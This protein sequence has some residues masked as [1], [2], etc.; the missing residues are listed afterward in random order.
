MSLRTVPPAI[1]HL[2]LENAQAL[3]YPTVPGVDGT[4]ILQALQRAMLE[5][6]TP[7]RCMSA[8]LRHSILQT[9][10]HWLLARPETLASALHL[11]EHAGADAVRSAPFVDIRLRALERMKNR[12]AMIRNVNRLVAGTQLTENA[13][14]LLIAAIRRNDIAQLISLPGRLHEIAWGPMRAD[15]HAQINALAE[16]M[17]SPA[18]S[19]DAIRYVFERST[20]GIGDYGTYRARLLLGVNFGRYL[21]YVRD[22]MSTLSTRREGA[23]SPDAADR[24]LIGRWSEIQKRVQTPDNARVLAEHDATRSLLML[25]SHSGANAI[26]GRALDGCRL[27]SS[28]IS[29]NVSADGPD[30]FNISMLAPDSALRF[31][32]LI[33][34]AK[35]Q[36]RSIFLFPDGAIGDTQVI[37]V[38]GRKMRIG[39]GAASLAYFTRAT[40]Y[41]AQTVLEDTTITI[42]LRRGPDC[43]HDAEKEQ[44]EQRLNDFYAECLGDILHGPPENIGNLIIPFTPPKT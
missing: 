32:K 37:E 8:D 40:P 41:F 6:I 4:A 42:R 35:R 44:Y 17:P 10:G 31:A 13:E 23:P 11:S 27:P 22:R 3:L 5:Q 26:L 19:E 20:S 2:G 21:F 25:G 15:L 9:A 36:P 38:L 39:K 33:K 16:V 28:S 29:N 7:D 30:T 34:M 14:T 24:Q 12:G 18:V 43:D 1:A